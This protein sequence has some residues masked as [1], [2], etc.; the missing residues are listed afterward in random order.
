[1]KII[2][3]ILC[4]LFILLKISIF[5]Q[6]L[7][8]NG[9]FET[10]ENLRCLDCY[11][12]QIFPTILKGWYYPE[13]YSPYICDKKY[14]IYQNNICNFSKYSA[15]DGATHIELVL[16]NHR[17]QDA[18]GKFGGCDEQGYA[19][20]LE[21]KLATPLTVGKIYRISASFYVIQSVSQPYLPN[22]AKYIGIDVNNKP[23]EIRQYPCTRSSLTPFLLDTILTDIWVEKKW[24]I[25]PSKPLDY[26][27]IGIFLG[28]EKNPDIFMDGRYGVDKISIQEVV[29]SNEYKGKN[30]I[31][32]PFPKNIVQNQ[33]IDKSLNK[34]E[35]ITIDAYFYFSPN[36]I[37]L[38]K[39][40]RDKLDSLS[41]LLKKNN[42]ENVI[43]IIGHT[44]SVGSE[45]LNKTLSQKRAQVVYNYL[46][47]KSIPFY[48]LNMAYLGAS[49][50][51]LS[52]D[53]ENGRRIN[54]RVQIK[55]SE[56]GLSEQY[57]YHASQYALAN[58]ID[59]AFIFLSKWHKDE[60]SFNKTV[61]LFDSDLDALR[62][63]KKWFYFYQ[64]I[65][66]FFKKFKNPDYA[67]L[68]DSLGNA[69]QLYRTPIFMYEKKYTPEKFDTLTNEDNIK[70]RT[71]IDKINLQE[72]KNLLN[73]YGYPKISEVG[74]KS[75]KTAFLILDHAD[76][77]TM[78]AFLP[79]LEQACKEK[80]A[81]GDWYAT[82]F[83]RILIYEGK[84][85]KYGTQYVL[86]PIEPETYILGILENPEKV[87][88]YRQQMGMN[89]LSENDMQV[90]IKFKKSKK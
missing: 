33:P 1:M 40:Q 43:D 61:V 63:D 81:K 69:D 67:F 66:R 70:I 19:N 2:Q 29:D 90:K 25:T 57:Y 16:V 72:L 28:E 65:K 38:D 26:V 78:K 24:Y 34:V 5:S 88:E 89:L 77:K 21:R 80:E 48:C 50:P 35:D 14:D 52:N 8:A 9:S 32:Y 49:K 75:A 60:N 20:Y 76:L 10:H 45:Q 15:N 55:K 51:L 39:I 64:D 42:F 23:L 54:R 11:T 4:S 18:K 53:S 7:V 56:Y 6:N 17:Q 46:L 86:S 71:D 44:D 22:Y 41:I 59:S 31:K 12:P 74:K 36:S 27:Q 73:K 13:W 47:E 85:Q 87:N 37:E 58:K 30:V 79:K 83:D 62:K 84:P 68:L 3:T 82:M